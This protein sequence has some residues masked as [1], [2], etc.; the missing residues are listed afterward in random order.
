M[1]FNEILHKTRLERGLTAQRIADEI[2]M[3]LRTYRFYESGH[4]QPR[5]AT[6]VKIADVLDVSVA[7]LLGRTKNKKSL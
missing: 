6:L 1:K 4:R 3:A 5:L 7:Y 2:G